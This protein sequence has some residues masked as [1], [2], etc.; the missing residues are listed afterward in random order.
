MHPSNLRFR[1]AIA[2]VSILAACTPVYKTPRSMP[3]KVMPAVSLEDTPPIE[4][5]G[6]VVLDNADGASHVKE[7][8]STSSYVGTHVSGW[9]QTTA[10]ICGTPCVANLPY[11]QHTLE[12]RSSMEDSY[13]TTINVTRKPMVHRV[14]NGKLVTHMGG[15]VTGI[16]LLSLGLSVGIACL[17]VGAGL[18]NSTLVGVGVGGIAVGGV[19]GYVMHASRSEITPGAMVSFP[20]P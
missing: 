11:G 1:A 17:G 2:A 16:M 10:P 14:A 12:F 19:G 9:G 15:L 7:I 20:I 4:G 18:G 3:D 5:M 8:L 13:E 6:Q